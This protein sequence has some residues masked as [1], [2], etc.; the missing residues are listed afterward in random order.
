[1]FRAAIILCAIAGQVLSAPKPCI[2]LLCATYHTQQ[3][4]QSSHPQQIWTETNSGVS[5]HHQKRDQHQDS[6]KIEL[7]QN[8]QQS[9]DLSQHTGSTDD[10]TKKTYK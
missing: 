7:G 2:D 8:I 10:F 6:G 1:M 4:Q 3:T 5:H 9:E